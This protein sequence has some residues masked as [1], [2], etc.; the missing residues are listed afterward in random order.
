MI[1]TITLAER[2]GFGPAGY[3]EYLTHLYRAKDS[4]EAELSL[5]CSEFKKAIA[6]RKFSIEDIAKALPEGSLLYEIFQYWP[7]NFKEVGGRRFGPRRYLAFTLDRSGEITLTDLGSGKHIDSLISE[8]RIKMDVAYRDIIEIGEKKAE[9]ELTAIS[10]HLYDLIFA[11]LEKHLHGKKQIL[12][13]PDGNINLLPFEILP[14]PD[15]KYILEK[16]NV[17]YLTCGRDLLKYRKKQDSTNKALVIADPD[18]ELSP[19]LQDGQSG[20]VPNYSDD[21]AF[22]YQPSRGPSDCLHGLFGPLR[23]TQNETES[24]VKILES[25]AGLDVDCY[26]GRDA[27]ETNLKNIDSPP[28][29]LHIATHGYFCEDPDQIDENPLLR[30]GLI[31]AGANSF[32]QTREI[33]ARKDDGILTAFE[34]SGL[35]LVGTELVALPAC[36]TGIGAVRIGEGVFGLRRAFQHAGALSVMMSLWSIPDKQTRDLMVGF[37]ERWLLGEPKSV[38]LRNAA[39]RILN[40][41]RKSNGSAHPVFW[42]GF[43][44][45]GN[46]Q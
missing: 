22:D 41:R 6:D 28:K 43:V 15:G 26:Y 39:I 23:Y 27:L 17:S 31:L 11:P 30:S 24:I 3:V 12:I 18:F 34:V 1:S 16:Y 44:L 5:K 9:Q 21:F 33:G 35:N 20:Q 46:P 32:L 45:V 36:K 14:C 25:K 38:A 19:D 42:G 10:R 37:Y 40:D 2:S 8:C 4:L 29:V 7:Y 13:S